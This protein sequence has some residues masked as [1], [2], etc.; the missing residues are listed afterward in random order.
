MLPIERN[1]ANSHMNM[2]HDMNTDTNLDMDVVCIRAH[3]VQ[4]N[5]S[6]YFTLIK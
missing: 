2:D 4:L 3:V 1:M 6:E 5:M